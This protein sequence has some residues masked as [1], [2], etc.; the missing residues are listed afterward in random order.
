LIPDQRNA[1]ERNTMRQGLHQCAKASLCH[2][3]RHVGKH[4]RVRNEGLESD[5]G[6]ALNCAGSRA[7]PSVTKPRTGKDAR[8]SMTRCMTV[9]CPWSSVLRL[10]STSGRPSSGGQGRVHDGTP[11]SSKGVPT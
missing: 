4:R 11:A 2:H 8:D 10:T 6:G 1:D 5:I 3:D 9:P 7:G